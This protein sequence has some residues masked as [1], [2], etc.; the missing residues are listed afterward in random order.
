MDGPGHGAPAAGPTPPRAGQRGSLGTEGP[1]LAPHACD[2][3]AFAGGCLLTQEQMTPALGPAS[4]ALPLPSAD[5]GR[6]LRLGDVRLGEEG[7]GRAEPGPL[8][9]L[10]PCHRRTC[11]QGPAGL[12]PSLVPPSGKLPQGQGPSWECSLQPGPLPGSRAVA[13]VGGGWEALP[14]HPLLASGVKEVVGMAGA[15]AGLEPSVLKGSPPPL[16]KGK[17]APRH[18]KSRRGARGPGEGGSRVWLPKAPLCG[19]LWAC[20]C[21]LELGI[22]LTEDHMGGGVLFVK[23]QLFSK[24]KT[25]VIM[26][27]IIVCS[28]IIK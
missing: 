10:P 24:E 13:G 6:P 17:G 26:I 12:Q 9:G 3:A 23:G 14:A 15:G 11:S 28:C 7:T 22:G 21:T 27:M 16:A 4:G 25:P 8:L 5:H 1:V 2:G 20:L 19:H 18:L